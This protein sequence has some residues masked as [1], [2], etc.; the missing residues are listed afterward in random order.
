MR[1]YGC[2][3]LSTIRI[4]TLILLSTTQTQAFSQNLNLLLIGSDEPLKWGVSVDVNY[5]SNVYSIHD[6]NTNQL[7]NPELKNNKLFS[8]GIGRFSA[9]MKRK[10]CFLGVEKTYMGAATSNKDALN[11]YNS[12]NSQGFS[13]AS[14]SAYAPN[15]SYTALQGEGVGL[16]CTWTSNYGLELGGSV[17][18]LVLESFTQRSYQGSVVASPNSTLVLLNEKWLSMNSQIPELQTDQSTGKAYTFDLE[19]GYR[20]NDVPLFGK[21]WINN[22]SNTVQFN[23]LP[24]LYRNLN[25]TFKQGGIFQNGHIP[26]L[27][28]RYGNDS[29][30]LK[31]PRIWSAVA[32]Y[33]VSTSA[34][35]GLRLNGVD[36][37]YQTMIQTTFRCLECQKGVGFDVLL[38]INFSNFGLG[39]TAQNWSIYWG[40]SILQGVG[41][42]TTNFLSL[43]YRY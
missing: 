37:N 1:K 41:A 6:L 16:G 29:E 2:P 33:Q 23:E 24:Y 9:Q 40:T 3:S 28:G 38:D 22:L 4:S 10:N 25:A 39:Y 15:V 18:A 12:I 19:V 42:N 21:V 17:H 8:S 11:I 35:V 14:N 27:S 5:A 20:Q 43:N 36:L 34:D 30:A 31:I 32:G 7:S 13:P 26:P